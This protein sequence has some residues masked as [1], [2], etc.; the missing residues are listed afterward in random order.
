MDD[1]DR[2]VG[3]SAEEEGLDFSDL[4]GLDDDEEDEGETIQ[5]ESA[6]K[7]RKT[8]NGVQVTASFSEPSTRNVVVDSLCSIFRW[9]SRRTPSLLP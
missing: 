4:E 6:N 2:R 5:L 7:Y 1:T 8:N 3:A 9:S